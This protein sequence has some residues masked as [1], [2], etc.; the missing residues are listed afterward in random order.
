MAGQLEKFLSGDR[1]PN[2][3]TAIGTCGRS[4]ARPIGAKNGLSNPKRV[5]SQGQQFLTGDCIP[6]FGYVVQAYRDQAQSI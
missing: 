5:V 6:N 2:P 1:I 4:Q 3:C